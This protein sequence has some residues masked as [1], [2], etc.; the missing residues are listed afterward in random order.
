MGLARS[1]MLGSGSRRHGVFPGGRQ[2]PLK[3][4]EFSAAVSR[5]SQSPILKFVA[6]YTSRD[7]F[8]RE[9]S[10]APADTVRPVD[11]TVAIN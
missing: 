8:S 11:H 5:R 4:S 3:Y 2:G 10:P 6:E 7:F 9:C 1:G